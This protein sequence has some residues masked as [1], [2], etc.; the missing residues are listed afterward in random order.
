[1]FL[2]SLDFSHEKST[3]YLLPSHSIVNITSD[4]KTAAVTLAVITTTVT[5]ISNS[6][7]PKILINS[8]ASSNSIEASP[9]KKPRKQLM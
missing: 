8:V 4:S 6:S 5:A 9:K 1:M 2:F 3:A 7:K